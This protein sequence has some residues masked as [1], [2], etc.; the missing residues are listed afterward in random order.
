MSGT[1]RSPIVMV[2]DAFGAGTV[3]ATRLAVRELVHA[4]GVGR[5]AESAALLTTELM[6]DA[7]ER[8][9]HALIV[10]AECDRRHVRVEIS[11]TGETDGYAGASSRASG[12]DGLRGRLLDELAD[13]WGSIRT[14]DGGIVWFDV[15]IRATV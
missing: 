15:G 4:A 10:Y 9:P 5:L 11:E 6:A 1:A 14:R 7:V 2:L 3:A 8:E 12:V 13:G